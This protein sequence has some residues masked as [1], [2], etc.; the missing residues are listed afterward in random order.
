MALEDAGL[1]AHYQ[2]W[3]ADIARIAA[4]SPSVVLVDMTEVSSAITNVYQVCASSG[5]PPCL[6]R[7]LTH[8]QPQVGAMII[9]SG[10]RAASELRGRAESDGGLTHVGQDEFRR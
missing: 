4:R 8:Y 5:E 3:Q 10:L 6:F 7:D 2:L 1:A 9:A